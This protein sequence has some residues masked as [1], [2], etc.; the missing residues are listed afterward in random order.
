MRGGSRTHPE[1][2][3]PVVQTGV[4]VDRG[5]A[6]LGGEGKGKCEKSCRLKVSMTRCISNVTH[7]KTCSNNNIMNA[8][9]AE[10]KGK[11]VILKR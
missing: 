8:D 4:L 11:G 9:D 10:V 1:V 6:V 7:H 2:D 3:D 5:S